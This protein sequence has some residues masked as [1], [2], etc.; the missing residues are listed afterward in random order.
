S[1][2]DAVKRR[3]FTF[4]KGGEKRHDMTVW[5]ING[6]PFDPD[7]IDARV[8][9]GTTEEWTIRALNVPHPFHIHSDPF[10]VRSVDGDQRGTDNAG[11]K[12]VVNLDN[13]GRGTLLI[14][15]D[16]YP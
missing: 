13:G 10:E 2:A 8:R 5:T 9:Q 4:A 12:D 6:K 11:W 16:G 15:F 1:A 14:R 7:R 3:T